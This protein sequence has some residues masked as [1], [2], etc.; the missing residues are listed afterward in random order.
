MVDALSVDVPLGLAGRHKGEFLVKTVVLAAAAVACCSFN[1]IALADD[2]PWEVRLRA[3]YLSPAN[4]SD[5]IPALAVPEDAIHIKGKVI[6]DLDFE[7]FFTPHWSSELVLAYDSARVTLEKSALGGPTDLGTFRYLPPILTLKYNFLPEA[8]FR[9]YL[10]AGLNVTFISDVNLSV[11]TVG[12]LGLSKTSVGPAAQ[13]GFD[14]KF[15]EH[16]FFNADVKWARLRSDVKY[17]GAAISQARVDPFLFG[18]GIGYRFGG[19]S[20]RFALKKGST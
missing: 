7:Y 11:P 1:V 4:K 18:L 10:G 3:V 17:Q 9:P 2:D 8:D 19:R 12:P 5:A 13:A 20:Q 14:W 6:P 15:A 16:W